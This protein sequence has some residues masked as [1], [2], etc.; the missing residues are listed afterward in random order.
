MGRLA[1]T[2]TVWP[3]PEE[4]FISGNK[5]E[6]YETLRIASLS[7][8]VSVPMYAL[9]DNL[10]HSKSFQDKLRRG[11]VHGVLK[12]DYSMRGQ[13]VFS[14]HTPDLVDKLNMAVKESGSWASVRDFFGQPHWFIQP[15]LAQLMEIGEV[16]V[17]IV[18]GRIAYKMC[19][20]PKVGDHGAWIANDNPVIRPVHQHR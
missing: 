20:T 7:M 15:F 10:L 13:H 11:L 19:T 18:G 17:V 12:R 6:G 3:H 2:T 4:L 1:E 9:A 16:R 8:N 14:S 5:V